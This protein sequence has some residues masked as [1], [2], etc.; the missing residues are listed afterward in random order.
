MT[1][2][3]IDVNDNLWKLVKAYAII[4]N[5]KLGEALNRIL[6][7]SELLKGLANNAKEEN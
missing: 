5:V 2:K 4:H 7:S 6:K 3:L 1:K